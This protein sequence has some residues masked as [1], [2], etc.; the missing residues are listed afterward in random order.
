MRVDQSTFLLHGGLIIGKPLRPLSYEKLHCFRSF[1][2]MAPS[3]V[4]VLWH[5][6]DL[7]SKAKPKHLL[8]ALMHLKCYGTEFTMSSLL[9]ITRKTYQKWTR[10]VVDAIVAIAPDVVCT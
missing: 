7:P 10:V 2:G 1:F 3:S 4:A 6:I 8:W 9:R 5:R